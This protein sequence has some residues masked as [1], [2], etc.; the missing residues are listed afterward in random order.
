MGL[1]EDYNN[2]KKNN[3]AVFIKNY[4]PIDV[5]WE[6]ILLFLYNESIKENQDLIEK[7][8]NLDRG[9]DVFGNVLIQRPLWMAPQTGMVWDEN[10]FPEI[11]NFLKQ[12]NLDFNN[13]HNF[14]NCDSYKHWDS[15][16]CTC[17]SMWH[18]EGIKISLSNKFVGSHSDPW[19]AC[20]FQIKGT[21][22]WKITGT[23][24]VEYKLHEG[25]VLFFPKPTSHEVWSDEPRMGLLLYSVDKT[26]IA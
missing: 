19:D 9:V 20:Y 11:K 14:E 8:R 16:N 13:S 2:A 15:R 24:S 12:I 4:F 17:S 10:S 6:R 25:D 7:D 5:S 3:T 22:Y 26:G 18:S 1:L 21:S 23:D